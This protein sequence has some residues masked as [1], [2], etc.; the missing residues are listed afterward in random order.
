LGFDNPHGAAAWLMMYLPEES[1]SMNAPL[2][3]L[4]GAEPPTRDVEV[5]GT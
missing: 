3:A 1:F 5:S 2:G 4:D